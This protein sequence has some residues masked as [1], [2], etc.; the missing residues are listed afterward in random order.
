M[1]GDHDPG[2]SVGSRVAELRSGPAE[3]LL[4]QPDDLWLIRDARSGRS[5]EVGKAEFRMLAAESRQAWKLLMGDG[6]I[7]KINVLTD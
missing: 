3:S 6:L 5:A 7:G 4:E 2:P 1:G